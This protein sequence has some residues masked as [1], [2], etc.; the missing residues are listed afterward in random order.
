MFDEHGRK[1]DYIRISV[2]DL[3]NLRCRYCIPECGVEKKS[4]FDILRFEEI[5]DIIKASVDLGITKVR[6]TG[7]EPLVR[8]GIISLVAQISRISGIRDVTLTTNA[9]LL[10]QYAKQ[11]KEAGLS[12]VNI[13]LDTLD[14]EKYA[15]ISRGGDLS[16]AIKGI[17]AAKKTGLTP[18]KI[19]TVLMKDFNDNEID[20]F[21]KMTIDENIDVRFIELMPVGQCAQSFSEGKQISCFEVLKRFPGL[22]RLQSLDSQVSMNYQLPGAKGRVGLI[23]PINHRFCNQCNRLRITADGKIKPCLHS[24]QEIDIRAMKQAG[25]TYLEILEYAVLRKPNAH[26]LDEKKYINRSMNSI[27][28]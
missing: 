24:N 27:G 4:H 23:S 2:T 19:N 10:A 16:E 20:D 13:S 18:L 21:V 9:T 6:L 7:G 14:K 17:E 1:I 15:F 25:N 26:R 8:K 3:C 11:L 22:I 28:G 12:R 5:I